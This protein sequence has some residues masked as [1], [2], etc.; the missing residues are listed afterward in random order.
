MDTDAV[1]AQKTRDVFNSVPGSFAAESALNVV[2]VGVTKPGNTTDATDGT[3][4]FTINVVDQGRGEDASINQVLLSSSVSVA[5]A[6]DETA[7][8]LVRVINKNTLDQR[9]KLLP[10]PLDSL[11]L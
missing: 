8:S 5:T 11:L 6:V 1:I 9:W 10:L 3:S 7:R 4:G 2:T